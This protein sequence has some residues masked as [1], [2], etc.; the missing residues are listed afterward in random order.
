[1]PTNPGGIFKIG[2]D[3]KSIATARALTV[4]D[5]TPVGQPIVLTMSAT[6]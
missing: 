3:G 4:S 1:M 6:Q 2:T 5:V